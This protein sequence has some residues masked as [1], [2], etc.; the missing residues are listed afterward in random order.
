MQRFETGTDLYKIN[1]ISDEKQTNLYIHRE[2]NVMQLSQCLLRHITPIHNIL[3]TAP[4]L[5]ISYKALETLPED[6]NV[7]PK[8]LGAI[9]HN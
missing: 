2:R 3:S 8:H 1:R 9:I 7:M 6:G 5:S 4:Q